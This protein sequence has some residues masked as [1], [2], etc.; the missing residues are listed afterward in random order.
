M[1]SI[2]IGAQLHLQKL[3]DFVTYFQHVF[4]A[5]SNYRYIMEAIAL[6]FVLFMGAVT[7]QSSNLGFDYLVLVRQVLPI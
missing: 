2:K 6:V 4:S 5:N 3:S 7:A 1:L